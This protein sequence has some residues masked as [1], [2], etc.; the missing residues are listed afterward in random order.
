MPR[1]ARKLQEILD[2][3][4]E[5]GP[6]SVADLARLLGR[7][8][9]SVRWICWSA[10]SRGILLKD[11]EDRMALPMKWPIMPGGEPGASLVPSIGVVV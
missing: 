4:E 6:M 1:E 11:N 8:K 9:S 3:L 10:I 7:P 2:A 5:K